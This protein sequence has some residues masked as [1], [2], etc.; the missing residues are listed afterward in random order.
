MRRNFIGA[1]IGGAVAL[2]FPPKAKASNIIRMYRNLPINFY[3]NNDVCGFASDKYCSVSKLTER[4]DDLLYRSNDGLRF[5]IYSYKG[6][7]W[8]FMILNAKSGR[9]HEAIGCDWI[10]DGE[11]ISQV[12]VPEAYDDVV[13][14]DGVA[15]LL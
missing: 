11:Y 3:P 4:L 8:P 12:D 1:M 5:D 10:E 9:Y 2:I 7:Y 14:K 15:H 6:K 13:I